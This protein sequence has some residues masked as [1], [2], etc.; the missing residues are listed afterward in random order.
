MQE[1][2]SVIETG[3]PVQETLLLRPVSILAWFAGMIWAFGS[4]I[5]IVQFLPSSGRGTTLGDHVALSIMGMLFLGPGTYYFLFYFRR[6]VIAD[7]NGV[8]WRS[9]L[10]GWRTARWNEITDYYENYV[11]DLIGNNAHQTPV[12][13]IG[14]HSFALTSFHP[15]E[16]ARLKA[17]IQVRAISAKTKEWGRLGTRRIDPFPRTFR[18]WD[19]GQRLVRTIAIGLNLLFGVGVVGGAVAIVHT[20]TAIIGRQETIP[21]TIAIAVVGIVILYIPF[22]VLESYWEAYRRRGESLTVTPETLC[23]ENTATS[24][25]FEVPWSGVADYFYQDQSG[26]FRLKGFTI[27]LRG[28][29]EKLITWTPLLRESQLFLAIVQNYAPKPVNAQNE[30]DSW[31]NK[32]PKEST[33]GSD[34]S[35]WQSGAV[36]MGGR[37][38]RN[39]ST[40]YRSMLFAYVGMVLFGIAVGNFIDWQSPGEGRARGITEL[41]LAIALGVCWAWICY[42]RTRI[43]TNDMGITHFTPFTKKH[44]Y[45]YAVADYTDSRSKSSTTGEPI[46]ITGRDGK[47][48]FFWSTLNGYEELRDEIERLAPPPKTGWK[49]SN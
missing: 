48:M 39:Q 26:G 16:V 6:R 44:L 42:F 2:E 38:F 41:M 27:V 13:C 49:T 40:G 4:L 24:E 37:V 31:R 11:F 17:Q 25:R 30:M 45:W 14:K 28:V 8:R 43:E 32:S 9:L 21:V 20:T 47:R 23:Y 34:P 46:I 33:G 35:T 36:G 15:E 7:E 5:F 10:Q 1:T 12:I 29:D 3:E 18:Y 19:P 22:R